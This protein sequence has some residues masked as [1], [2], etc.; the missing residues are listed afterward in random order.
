VAR[1]FLVAAPLHEQT[2]NLLVTGRDL[3]FI[4]VD[5]GL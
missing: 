4:E 2:Q 3:D 5:H 1:D